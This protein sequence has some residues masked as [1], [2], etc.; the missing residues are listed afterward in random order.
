MRKKIL[1]VFAILVFTLVSI[2]AAFAGEPPKDEKKHTKLGKYVNAAEAYKMWE[3]DPEGVSIVDCRT[4]EEYV[5]VGHPPMAH[6]IPSK[7]WTGKWD[8]EK[9]EFALATNENFEAVI[10]ERFKPDSVIL[11]M[12]RSGHRSA[13]SV[14][15]LA[16]AGFTNVYNITDGF[17]G[18]KIKDE[19]S[20][21][22]GK[23]KKN[24]WR[25]SGAPWTYD[26]NLELLHV[27]PGE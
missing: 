18:D 9:K 11:I 12:C 2:F 26:L 25:N 5:Y 27:A 1:A 22:D 10:K 21:Y 20:Y 17:E 4:P 3:A 7:L 8:A 15:R 16:D 23:R 24:G 14:N 13:E 19:E 6:N